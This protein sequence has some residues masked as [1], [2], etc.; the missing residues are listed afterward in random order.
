MP[1]GVPTLEKVISGVSEKWNYSVTIADYETG[2]CDF[3]QGNK[4]R[5]HCSVEL[6]TGYSNSIC[7]LSINVSSRDNL[8]YEKAVTY[9]PGIEE[10]K[11]SGGLSC[12]DAPSGGPTGCSAEYMDWCSCMKGSFTCG[13]G[14]PICLIP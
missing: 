13:F 4:E 3:I 9:M 11:S 12:G 10:A 1:G 6:P 7:Y 5:L 2:S 14:G 8:I